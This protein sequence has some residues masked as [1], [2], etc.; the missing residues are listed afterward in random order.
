MDVDLTTRIGDLCLT[1]PIILAPAPCGRTGR[2]LKKAAE[3]GAGAV[4][5]KTI[6]LHGNPPQP[7]P[8]ILKLDIGLI[9]FEGNEPSCASFIKELKTAREAKVPIIASIAGSNLEENIALATALE[10]AG[11]SA[12]E[13][14][15]PYCLEQRTEQNLV[16][17]PELLFEVAHEVRKAINIP[18][19]GKFSMEMV[20]RDPAK[21][22]EEA[23][24]DA[25]SAIDAIG[26]AMI[27]NP[28]IGK[29]VL[30]N[31]YGTGHISGPAIR[32]IAIRCVADLSRLVN[33]PIIGI[34]GI[35]CGKDAIEM[36]M[37]GAR[38][39]GICSATI[40]HGLGVFQE[41]EDEMKNYLV[42]K[43]YDSI[44]HIIGCSLR[45]LPRITDT[46]LW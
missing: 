5:T 2:G 45:H 36:M 22:F 21:K 15:I 31:R 25:I 44:R 32:Y 7:P 29:P 27:I 39:V 19:W 11:A 30:K 38:A 17:K 16:A 6:T 8:S 41:I 28:D 4:M 23:G 26:P 12:I 20:R 42:E 40:T 18:L 1:N 46:Q 34:G 13:L 43:G 37:V 10:E 3:A 24:A 14:C 33:I 9:N 35:S